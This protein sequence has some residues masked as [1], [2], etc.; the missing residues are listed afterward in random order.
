M[1]NMSSTSIYFIN[2]SYGQSYKNMTQI[3]AC[4]TYVWCTTEVVISEAEWECLT[5]L[6][7]TNITRVGQTCAWENN[8]TQSEPG[9]L[10]YWVIL[11]INFVKR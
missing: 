5:N 2:L 6:M 7:A 11:N 8:M 4:T 3:Y 9:S 10:Y 1:N